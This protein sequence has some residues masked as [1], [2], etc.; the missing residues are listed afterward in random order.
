MPRVAPKVIYDIK[1]REKISIKE[2]IDRQ[3]ESKFSKFKIPNNKIILKKGNSYSLITLFQ[4]RKQLKEK[5]IKYNQL[6]GNFINDKD[7][8]IIG[9][10]TMNEVAREL[11]EESGF[12]RYQLTYNDRTSPWFLYHFIKD[13]NLDGK[14]KIIIAQAGRILWEDTINIRRNP[15][16]NSFYKWWKLVNGMYSLG[17]IDSN[18]HVWTGAPDKNGNI[19]YKHKLVIQDVRANDYYELPDTLQRNR[20]LQFYERSFDNNDVVAYWVPEKNR[21]GGDNKNYTAQQI[22]QTF[23]DNETKSCFFD[24]IEAYLET[25]NKDTPYNKALLNKLQKLKDIHADGVNQKDIQS[26][27]NQLNINV[28]INDIFNNNLIL[29]KGKGS[30]V[31]GTIKY[32][33]TYLNHLDVNE[34]IDNNSEELIN[35]YSEMR[36][37]INNCIKNKEYF[38]YKGSYNEPTRI[39]T[40]NKVYK[41]NNLVN[42]I[43]KKF[44]DD[45][46][47]YNYAIDIKEQQELY[48]F[49]AEGVN[50]NAHYGFRKMDNLDYTEIENDTKRYTEYDMKSAY[51][52][53]KESKYYIGFPNIMTPELQLTN[54]TVEDCKKYIGYYKIYIKSISDKNKMLILSELGIDI[55][56]YYVLTSPEVVFISSFCN[57][58]IIS[59][60]YSYEPLHIDFNNDML[61]KIKVEKYG[62]KEI[63]Q[64]PY[65]IWTGKLNSV[66][67]ET[68]LRT[69]I[70]RDLVDVLQE[71]YN[72][73]SFIDISRYSKEFNENVLYSDNDY[74]EC[75][76]TYPNKNVKWLGHI[77]GFIT[78]YTRI[79]VLELLLQFKHNQILGFKLDGFVIE[80]SKDDNKI[81]MDKKLWYEA[82]EKPTK[83][84]FAWG[85]RIY[86]N[87]SNINALFVHTIPKY[88]IDLFKNR[89]TFLT[90][91]GGC[92]KSHSVLDKLKDTIYL[93]ACWS[94][95][96]AK[97]KEYNIKSMSIHQFI[98]I[99]CESYLDRHAPPFR[100]LIDE[101]TM[102]DKKYINMIIQ[103]CPYSQIFIAGDID[104]YGYYQCAFKDV[105][106]I[107]P[108]DNKIVNFTTNY[109]CK[110]KELLKRL[111]NL[112][113]YMKLTNFHNFKIKKYVIKEFSDRFIDKDELIKN[114]DYK[115]DW[116][117]VSITNTERS[118]TKYYSEL[119]KGKKYICKKHSK[120]DVYK[121]LEGKEAYL[122][123]DIIYD[124]KKEQKRFIQQD[125]FTIHGF[126]GKT[127]KNPDALF[128]DLNNIFCPRQLYTALSRVEYLNQIYLLL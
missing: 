107:I 87:S 64:K 25:K 93:S 66:Y 125:A 77:G 98:G 51:T 9:R 121:R 49:L 42:N 123:G 72:N 97:S 68:R 8:E 28:E 22:Y 76:V 48:N 113:E 63:T 127:I 4:A 82:G 58:D 128:I 37:I 11:D 44:N 104:K 99:E 91:A 43:I 47:I 70:K 14:G 7:E 5:K 6:I 19:I 3:I 50:Y 81:N 39:Y 90:G 116:V 120:D 117:L 118:Q 78:A 41:Y 108:D 32:I 85:E 110:D 18:Q 46:K 55:N 105:D 79:H 38:Y 114:Y 34:F 20:E 92:G 21:L 73:I 31:R 88:N 109:R 35:K 40:K 122:T 54:W 1:R 102:I 112:R 24:G 115:K 53:Y 74:I 71:N 80:K 84:N 101:I 103:K 124:L 69:H 27:C 26:I 119:L 56:N 2:A 96:V 15:A 29:V 23:R 62:R 10:R 45:N 13:N 106:V 100:I 36:E 83:C 86:S 16:T 52:K 30:R 95:C 65:A 61:E 67:E 94:L 59:G 111:N 75:N 57:I 126:Q 17:M 89:I 12:K 60:S 33:N